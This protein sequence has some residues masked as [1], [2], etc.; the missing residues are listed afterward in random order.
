MCDIGHIG[1]SVSKICYQRQLSDVR[2]TV[3]EWQENIER[4]CGLIPVTATANTYAISKGAPPETVAFKNAACS[5]TVEHTEPQPGCDKV[6]GSGLHLYA[7]VVT[8]VESQYVHC[9]W[10]MGLAC[11]MPAL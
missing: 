10:P 1:F 7:C 3:V 11:G 8:H 5:L 9:P 6:A 2:R 4:R